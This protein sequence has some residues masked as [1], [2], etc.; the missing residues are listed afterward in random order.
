MKN[1]SGKT[2]IFYTFQSGSKNV[3]FNVTTFKKSAPQEPKIRDILYE[4]PL[5]FMNNS[6][7]FR[8]R[9]EFFEGD[10]KIIGW[11][12][13]SN[14]LA[15]VPIINNSIF[16]KILKLPGDRENKLFNK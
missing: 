10:E 6:F 15:K 16:V 8:F 3:E 7:H 5:D 4:L 9:S 11:I 13:I 12:D 2:M 14:L 1:I